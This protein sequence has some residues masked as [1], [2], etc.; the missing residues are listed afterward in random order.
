LQHG[1]TQNDLSGW[2]NKLDKNIRLFVTSAKP[3]YRSIIDGDYLYSKNEVTLTGLPRYDKLEN[4]P[5]KKILI[6]PTWRSFLT[7]KRNNLGVSEKNPNFTKSKFYKFYNNLINNRELLSK[8]KEKD[9]KIK[10]CLHP[11]MISEAETFKDNKYVEVSKDIC[12]Y[13]KEFSEG[14]LLVTDYSSVAFDFA[15]LRKPI[16]YSQFDL[17]DVYSKHTFQK[18]YFDYKE[19]GFG[20]VCKDLNSTV[21]SI[22]K[23]LDSGCKIEKRYRDRIDRFFEYNDRNNCKRVYENILKI[24]DTFRYN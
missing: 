15:Y 18:G 19:D 6:M 11:A 22:I 12:N 20:P 24:Q 5:Q 14:S 7:P 17:K 21:D 1:I 10:L 3:E 16:I 4:N 9:Y 23:I 2:L 8:V 13:S